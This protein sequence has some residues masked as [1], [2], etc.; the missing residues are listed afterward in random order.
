MRNAALK[1]SVFAMSFLSSDDRVRQEA[2]AVFRP[3]GARE[4]SFVTPAATKLT[5]VDFEAKRLKKTRDLIAHCDA[6]LAAADAAGSPFVAFPELTGLLALGVLPRAG[7]ALDSLRESLADEEDSA[8]AALEAVQIT[9][10]FLGEFFLNAFSELSRAR[11]LLIAAGGFYVA[12]G[13]RIL[14]RQFLFSE[15]GEVLTHQDKLILSPFERALG[16][17]PCDTICPADTRIGRVAL[18]TASCAPHYEPFAAAAALGC[19]AVTAGASP[20]EE[21]TSLLRCRAQEQGLCVVSPGLHGGRDFGFSFSAKPVIYAP[22]STL[23]AR[24]G[25]AARGAGE[26]AVTARIDLSGECA[27]GDH[28]S[29]DRNAAFFEAL[30]KKEI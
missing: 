12:E 2:R 4:L 9:Q 15:K 5:A 3:K 13:G 19:R 23:R 20:F 28:Y 29:A 10:G 27:A 14:N 1:S 21:D 25:V 6:Y 17:S 11:G 16:I 22:R 8:A 24:D 30:L 18:L 7:A 26:A